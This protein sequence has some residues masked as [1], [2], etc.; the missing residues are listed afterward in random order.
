LTFVHRIDSS[1]CAAPIAIVPIDASTKGV[2]GID[3]RL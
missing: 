3:C 1:S 2:I